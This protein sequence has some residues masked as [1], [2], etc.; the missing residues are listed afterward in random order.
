MLVYFMT[1]LGYQS[2]VK[3]GSLINQSPSGFLN[4]FPSDEFEE[5]MY[6]TWSI[7][8]EYFIDVKKG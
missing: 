5:V 7:P 3:R 1:G 6:E 2:G 8:I 4:F